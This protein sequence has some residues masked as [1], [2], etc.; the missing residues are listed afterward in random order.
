MSKTFYYTMDGRDCEV[1]LCE[2]CESHID[3]E[4]MC[5][6][7]KYHKSEDYTRVDYDAYY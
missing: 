7:G 6:C 5:D 1:Q 2:K 3:M 4:G